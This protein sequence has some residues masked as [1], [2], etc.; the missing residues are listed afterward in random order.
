MLPKRL[1]HNFL[2]SAL[3]LALSAMAS[4]DQLVL[5]NGDTLSGELQEQTDTYVI[6]PRSKLPRKELQQSTACH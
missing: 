4:A 6:W 5:T 3:G 1:S 2:F